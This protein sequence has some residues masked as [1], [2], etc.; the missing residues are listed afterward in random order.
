MILTSQFIIFNEAMDILFYSKYYE[1]HNLRT[2][3]KLKEPKMKM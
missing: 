1:L 3:N 2:G